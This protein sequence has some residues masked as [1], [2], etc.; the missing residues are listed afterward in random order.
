M[1]EKPHFLSQQILKKY[2][3]VLV[4]FALNSGKGVGKGEVVRL[5]VPD[6]AKALGLEL[7]NAVLKAGAYPMMRFLPTNF[8]KDFYTLAN[9]DQLT[10]FPKKFSRAQVDLIDHTLGI[11]ADPDPA[12]LA[13]VDPKKIILARDSKKALRDWMDAKEQA[14]KYTWT[15]GLW[16]VEAKAKEVGLTLQEYWDQIIKACYLDKENPVEE[17]RQIAKFQER[18][19]KV[20]NE[21]QIEYVT[22]KGQDLDLRV[23][24][25]EKRRWK[26]GEGRNIPSF[27]IFTSP[28]LARHR[29]LDQI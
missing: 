4:N 26:G 11:L 3:D 24:I 1:F 17:W 2:A 15:M 16:G 7:Q 22:V 29:G 23:R 21:M 13:S 19:K 18:V 25:G 12:E 28:D 20:L 5:V 27:E 14:G 8:D 10:F 6:V 9:E